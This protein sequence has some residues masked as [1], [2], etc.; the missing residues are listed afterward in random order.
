MES[1]NIQVTL[2]G[3]G[4]IQAQVG[5]SALTYKWD[6]EQKASVFNTYI[7]IRS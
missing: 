3:L 1:V 5:A 2:Y 7:D 4:Y 6:A